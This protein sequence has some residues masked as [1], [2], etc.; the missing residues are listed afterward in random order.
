M[1]ATKLPILRGGVGGGGVGN[2]SSKLVKEKIKRC[3]KDSTLRFSLEL[4]FVEL[5]S[6][7]WYLQHLAQNRYF[8]DDA[9]LKYIDYLQYWRKPEYVTYIRHPH[10]LYFLEMLQNK[11]FRDAL[12]NPSYVALIHTNQYWH[13]YNFRYNR[14]TAHLN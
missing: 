8:E 2:S 5:L 13:W 9:F 14:Y 1:S 6:N 12:L 11:A 3:A 10:S 4:E 7:P